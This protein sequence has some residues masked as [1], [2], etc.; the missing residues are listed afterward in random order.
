MTKKTFPEGIDGRIV[1]HQNGEPRPTNKGIR[2]QN[3]NWFSTRNRKKIH[4]PR[5]E[6][7]VAKP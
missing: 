2:K 5:E 6:V 3:S 7:N 4:R 1:Q